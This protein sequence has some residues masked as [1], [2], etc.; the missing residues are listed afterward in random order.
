MNI[1]FSRSFFLHVPET[2]V[3]DAGPMGALSRFPSGLWERL[4]PAAALGRITAQPH[5]RQQSWVLLQSA[6]RHTQWLMAFRDAIC[7][8]THI[9]IRAS[10]Q[11]ICIETHVGASWHQR[12]HPHLQLRI[13]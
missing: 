5:P 12:V 9:G 6:L 11:T 10:W 8:Q 3:A 2:P 7:I 13:R 1:R 4:P